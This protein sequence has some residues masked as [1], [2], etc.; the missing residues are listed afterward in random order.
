MTNKLKKSGLQISL[1]LGAVYDW[2]FGLSLLL[3]P[4]LL[5][6]IISLEMPAEQIYLRLNG[7]FLI[8]IGV[9]YALYW[10]HREK[11]PAVPLIA[12]L[13]RFSGLIFFTGAW[14][15]FSYPITFL[16]L[17]LGD[18]L[19]SAIHLTLILKEKTIKAW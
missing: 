11:Y 9:F 15:L 7:L 6:K 8:I 10:F 14:A 1:L 2:F 12:V 3:I 19:W 13:A 4:A 5:A 16:L 17:G 18:G